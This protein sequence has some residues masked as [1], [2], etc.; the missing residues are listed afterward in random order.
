MKN[1]SDKDA[2]SKFESDLGNLLDQYTCRYRQVI[3]DEIVNDLVS[4]EQG[5]L[6]SLAFEV[7]RGASISQ[8]AVAQLT[9][10]HRS[11]EIAHRLVAV[12]DEFWM[13][14]E[15]PTPAVAEQLDP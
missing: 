2:L 11:L 13:P 6:E 8:D 15:A 12:L 1:E 10:L 4:I 9:R 3:R 7:E 5:A 14:A